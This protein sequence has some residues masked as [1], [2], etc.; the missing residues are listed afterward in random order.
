MTTKYVNCS[1]RCGNAVE[2]TTEMR[3]GDQA[4]LCKPCLSKL[5]GGQTMLKQTEENCYELHER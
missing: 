5:V 1:Q 3:K 2:V 4:V